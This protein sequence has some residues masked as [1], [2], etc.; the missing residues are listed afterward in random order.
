MAHAVLELDVFLEVVGRAV[1]LDFAFDAKLVE[2]VADADEVMRVAV[3][4]RE[5]FE[6]DGLLRVS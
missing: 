2:L 6:Y 3:A 4:V 1:G 5:T